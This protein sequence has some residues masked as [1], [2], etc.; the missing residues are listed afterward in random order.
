[1]WIRDGFVCR[2]FDERDAPQVSER[3]RQV[4]GDHYPSAPVSD[5]RYFVA[6]NREGRLVSFI[7]EDRARN[8]VGHAALKRGSAPYVGLWELVHGVVA[9]EHRGVGL[10]GGLVSLA[11]GWARGSGLVRG[12]FATAV[13]NHTLSQRLFR[14]RG[15]L[16]TGFEIDHVPAR[17]FAG[18]GGVDGPVSTVVHYVP[19]GAPARSPCWVPPGMETVIGG[20]LE[21]IGETGGSPRV[22]PEQPLRGETDCMLQDLRL[23]DQVRLTARRCG[24]DFDQRLATME[25]LAARSGSRVLQLILDLGRQD[26]GPAGA[27]ALRRGYWFSAVLPRWFDSHGLLLQKSLEPPGFASIELHSKEARELLAHV[28]DGWRASCAI[29]HGMRL[30]GV[31]SR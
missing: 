4:Y 7:A 6:G 24:Q 26:T 17:A 27:L 11:L 5:P 19:I 29:E 18:E 28:Q 25:R 13:A 21:R 14:S 12:V 16:E 8:V 10:F 22:C 15:M 3:F 9:R 1:M 2:R 23:F 20:I 30:R 31:E